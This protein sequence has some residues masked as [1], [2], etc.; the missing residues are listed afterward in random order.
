MKQAVSVLEE[1]KSNVRAVE[2]ALDILLCFVERSEW[3]MTEIA[4]KVGL[5]KSTVHRMLATLEDRGFVARN[6]ATDRYRLGMRVWELTAH[7]S[8]NDDPSV[9]LLPEMELLR[10][11]LGET[12]SLYVRDG[13]ERIRIQA[14]QRNQAV[15]RVAN[16]GARLPL[17][18]GASSKVLLAFGDDA[19]R[20][21]VMEGEDWP[22]S[23]NRAA[24]VAKLEGIRTAGY[25]TSIEEREAG[26]A[27]VSAPIFDRSGKLA[28]ALSV[29]G[30]S[31]RL[32]EEMMRAHAPTI[33]EAAKRM[34]MMLVK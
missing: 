32:T 9:L 33:I 27:A 14:V 11:L 21:L 25:A 10:D 20:R 17:Y 7:L 34:G 26:A 18:V 12:V 1:G 31:G 5:H 3:A 16:V 19:T 29:S 30:P 23:M 6:P 8:S 28:A 22:A 4:E 24:Y 13:K 2:R 15:R